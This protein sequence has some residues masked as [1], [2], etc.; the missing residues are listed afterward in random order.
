MFNP[1]YSMPLC[2]LISTSYS[3]REVFEA[4]K[5][6]SG[7]SLFRAVVK[8]KDSPTFLGNR[9]GFR[10]INSFLQ[11]AEKYKDIA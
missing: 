6:S 10:I 3:N 11:Y 8:V 4:V 1:P 2:E 9:I 5:G 7:S